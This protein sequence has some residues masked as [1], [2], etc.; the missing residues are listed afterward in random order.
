MLEHIVQIGPMLVLAG[1]L[2]GWVAETVSRADGYGLIHDF[3]L[4]LVGS[5]LVGAAVWVTVSSDAGLVAMFL[6]GLAGAALPLVAQRTFWRSAR[7]GA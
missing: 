1:L 4:G 3:G 7:L 2:A 5:V 6:I